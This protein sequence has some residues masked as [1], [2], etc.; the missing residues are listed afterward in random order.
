MTHNA[1][2]VQPLNDG[3]LYLPDYRKGLERA[4]AD[5]SGFVPVRLPHTNLELPFNNF[6]ERVSQL[7]SCYRKH[8]HYEECAQRRV[9]LRFEGV[10]AAAKVY[11]D[12]EFLTEHFGGY[13]PFS[14]ELTGKLQ[15]GEHVLA[16]VADATERDDIPPFGYV[17][18]Y[19]TYG[20]I[21]REVWME[22]T[23]AVYMRNARV[24]TEHTEGRWRVETDVYL[25]NGNG[26]KGEASLRFALRG[27]DGGASMELPVRFTGESDQIVT[28]SFDAGDV[29]LW[30]LDAP[31]L[32]EMKLELQKD[33]VAL[34]KTVRRFGFR[35]AKFTP[36]GFT[37]NG[38]MVKLRGLNRH[39]S[40]PYV[41]YAM[42]KRA[43]ESDAELLKNGL[44][45]NFVRTSHYPQSRHFLNRCDELGLLVFE[46]IPGWQHIGGD[47]WKQNTLIA[48]REM[49][50]RDW[51]HPS[52][53]LWGVRVN[54]SPDDDAL[55]RETNALAKRLDPTRQTGGV[56]NF[57]HSH[58]FEDVYTYNDFLHDGATKPLNNP[59]SIV[60][61]R[62]PYMV[63]EHNGHMF[64]TK[65]FD[66]EQHR[67]EHALRHLRV[68]ERMYGTPGISGAVGWCMSDYNTHREFGS[69]DKIC[70]HGVTDM[71]RLPK[72]AA[73]VYRSQ[74]DGEAFMEVA[75][76]MHHG[77]RA[78]DLIERV[79]VFTN[80]DYVRLS[81]NGE[82]IGTCY[83]DRA[84]FPNLPHPPVVIT[85]FIGDLLE[86]REG[87][88][89]QDAAR[90]K[91]IFA[92]VV[93]YGAKP[94]P[95]RY[96]IAMGYAMLKHRMSLQQATDLFLRYAAGWGSESKEYL[97]EGFIDGSLVAAARR[98]ASSTE[99]LRLTPETTQLVEGDTYDVCRVTMEHLDQFGEV[100]PYSNEAVR[101]LAGGAGERIGPELIPLT[102]GSAAFWVR[103]A[104]EGDIIVSIE[105]QRFGKRELK[106]TATR[107]VEQATIRLTS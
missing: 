34:D 17:I 96:K 73:A 86:R 28:V 40:Y 35:E 29:Q 1:R 32:Y 46:E 33:G 95:L 15:D 106:L 88:S 24:K 16:V 13:T 89:A 38:K 25:D 104:G 7:I 9:F 79:Y 78:G 84:A 85:D 3:W 54:E 63:T 55:Y 43:Q 30:D 44:G 42:P 65:K 87:F 74:Q 26:A 12:G 67:V 4:G 91:C 77:E 100:M 98:G 41:G 64:P 83:P 97:F 80:C 102:G 99:G 51:N 18:D 60:R 2:K 68:L 57:A 61:G 92:A 21:Y 11:L 27:P 23:N 36:D 56:R 71:F 31:N 76:G 82:H 59:R 70:Y 53:V 19:L 103:S 62:V 50:E 6:D 93:R 81:Q 52:I 94:L 69:G 75:S 14:C 49:I 45:V 105:S 5:E 48:L 8:F 20:G 72:Y 47:E 107:C 37:L 10:M 101:V 66:D 22:E 58:F 90:I 39:Q